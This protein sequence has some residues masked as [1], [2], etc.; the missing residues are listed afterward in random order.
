MALFFDA[1]WFRARLA[2]RGLSEAA[3]A[4]SAGMS[5]AELALA[6][7]DQRELSARE[8]AAFAELLGVSPAEIAQRAGVSTPTPLASPLDARLARIEQRLDAIEAALARREPR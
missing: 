7:K 3:L 8:V 5:E 1:G 6:F 4:A 2:D